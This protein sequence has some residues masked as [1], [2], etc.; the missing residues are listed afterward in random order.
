M[1]E[2]LYSLR[3]V[4]EGC[5]AKHKVAPKVAK[6]DDKHQKVVSIFDRKIEQ[7]RSLNLRNSLTSSDPEFQRLIENYLAKINGSMPHDVRSKDEIGIAIIKYDTVDQTDL[8]IK[9]SI[10]EIAMGYGSTS[11]TDHMNHEKLMCFYFKQ[12]LIRYMENISTDVQ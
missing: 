11:P 6:N 4:V 9:F 7:G 2:G 12:S 5:V 8:L 1:N 10:L 3:R